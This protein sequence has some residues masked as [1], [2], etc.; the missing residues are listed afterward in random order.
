MKKSYDK[1]KPRVLAR[2]DRNCISEYITFSPD[3]IENI[4]HYLDER[5]ILLHNR[6]K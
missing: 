1:N 2:I 5:W 6:I 3:S 4:S